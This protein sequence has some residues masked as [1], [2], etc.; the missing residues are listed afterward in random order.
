MKN[1]NDILFILQARLGSSRVPK[2]MTRSF[3]GTSLFEIAINKLLNCQSIPKNQIYASIYEN[4][5]IEIANKHKINIYYRSEKSAKAESSLQ[6]IYEW[7]DKF[8]QFKYVILL[9]ACQPFL[10]TQT[11]DN[12]VN[13]F[14]HSENDGLFGVIKKKNYFWNNKHT[15]ITKWPEDQTIMNTKVVEETLEAAHSLYASRLDLI[16]NDMFMGNFTKNNPELFEMSE[17]ETFD[18]DYEWQFQMAEDHYLRYINNN[19]K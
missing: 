15:M 9:N 13:H 2:K 10:L 1:I 3:N 5:L 7:H 19:K 8:P 16:K 12:F 6:D 18:I 11:I 14:L 4:E 17:Y